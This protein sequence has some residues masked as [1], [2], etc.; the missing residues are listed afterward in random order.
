MPPNIESNIRRLQS[1]LSGWAK[2]GNAKE[3]TD[4]EA[5]SIGG[6]QS[7]DSAKT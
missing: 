2:A 6:E 3:K 5:S 7:S 4:A 1:D